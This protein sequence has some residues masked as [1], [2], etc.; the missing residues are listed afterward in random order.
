[1]AALTRNASRRGVVW[2]HTLAR[3]VA[4]RVVTGPLDADRGSRYAGLKVRASGSWWTGAS[5]LGQVR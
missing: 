2:V 3:S 1:M 4:P 5:L